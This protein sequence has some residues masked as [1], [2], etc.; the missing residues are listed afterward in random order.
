MKK[1]FAILL[2]SVFLISFA[3]AINWD[4][5]ITYENNDMK[6]NFKNTFGLGA[7]LGSVELKSHNSVNEVLQFGFGKEEVVM[8]YDFEFSEIYE[9]GLGDIIFTNMKNGKEIEKDYYF[10]EWKEMDFE[11]NDYKTICDENFINGTKGICEEIIIGTHLEKRFEWVKYN[12]LDIPVGN[13]R[14]GLKTYVAKDDYV[15]GVWTI[16]GKKVSKHSEWTAD[17]TVGLMV[18]YL[19]DE[20]SGT[21]ALDEMGLQNGTIQAGVTLG[22]EGIIGTAFNFTG[23]SSEVIIDGLTSTTTNYAFSFWAKPN[24]FTTINRLVF[25]TQAGRFFI[26]LPYSDGE[27]TVY[28]SADFGIGFPE[29]L[30]LKHY[31]FVVDGSSNN[32]TLYI[33]SVM[34]TKIGRA[35]V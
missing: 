21:N 6:V 29:A 8:Y 32:V 19:F 9:N 2:L 13:S 12:S 22:V 11:V 5:K 33:N 28:P 23:S 15:D 34:Q 20:T 24:V 18:Y 25:D 10:V 27:I 4:N 26:A 3:S 31:V 17:L 1:L 16:V 30:V 35:H 14:I 7:D